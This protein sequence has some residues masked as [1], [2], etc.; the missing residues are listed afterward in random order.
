[1]SL[2]NPGF[3]NPQEMIAEGYQLVSMYDWDIYIVPGAFY[4]HDYL[5]EEKLYKERT[6]AKIGR[7]ERF[8]EKH[9]S[10]LGGMFALWNDLVGNG[11]TVKDIHYRTF[12]A[13][14]TLAVKMW[15]G[16]N[17]TIPYTAFNETRA[18]LSEAPGVNLLGRVGKPGSLV[19]RK[20]D[21]P[22]GSKNQIQ[23]IGYGYTVNFDLT[24]QKEASGTVLFRSPDA[25][26]YLADPI[27]GFLG[28]ARDGYLD[29][30]RYKIREG[31]KINVQ[32]E[33]TS[34]TTTLKIDGKL[35]DQ[36]EPK[37]RYF[38]CGKDSMLYFRTL[39]FPLEEAGH[40]KSRVENLKVYNYCKE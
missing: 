35:I 3:A 14:Q 37:M 24:G 25:V 22:A 29:T 18:A 20:T 27:N 31:E 6:P 39:V 1:M 19:Y 2:W 23:E 34:R 11:I 10:I 17:T 7:N 12:P 33:G 8:E 16:K 28:F 40:F 9:P 36:L 32:I 4:Y 26:F 5:D 13:L 15:T 21:V 30:F 38:S